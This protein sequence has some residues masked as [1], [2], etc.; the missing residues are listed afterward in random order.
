MSS[1]ATPWPC[2]QA[3][4]SERAS[5][6]QIKSICLKDSPRGEQ[7]NREMRLHESFRKM[8]K[9]VKARSW[10]WGCYARCHDRLLSTIPYQRLLERAVA[11]VR[12]DLH[13]RALRRRLS[14]VRSLICKI[15]H[16]PDVSISND[17]AFSEHEINK[18]WNL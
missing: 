9:T 10:F 18:S 6:R 3:T 15:S 14:K 13:Q 4:T 7:F 2:R 11:C 5:R 17:K 16:A 8:M 12:G 1:S